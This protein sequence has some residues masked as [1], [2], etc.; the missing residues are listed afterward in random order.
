MCGNPLIIIPA[1]I[2]KSSG[3]PYPSFYAC[4]S[5]CNLKGMMDTRVS[6]ESP[7][8]WSS[9]QQVKQSIDTNTEV[10]LKLDEIKRIVNAILDILNKEGMGE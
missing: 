4:K 10:L 7:Q 6:A 3:K 5:R 1:G 2:S 8:E 9:T